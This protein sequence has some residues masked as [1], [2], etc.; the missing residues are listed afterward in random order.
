MSIFVNKLINIFKEPYIHGDGYGHIF[1]IS[2]VI[3]YGGGHMHTVS[4]VKPMTRV[5]VLH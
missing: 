1:F 3:G 5:K 2:M 4:V